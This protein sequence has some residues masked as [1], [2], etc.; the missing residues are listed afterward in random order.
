MELAEGGGHPM[1]PAICPSCHTSF[2]GL[3]ACPKCLFSKMTD[4]QILAS[5]KVIL[6]MANAK[7]AHAHAHLICSLCAGPIVPGEMRRVLSATSDAHLA[8]VRQLHEQLIELLPKPTA[9]GPGDFEFGDDAIKIEG[10]DN[11]FGAK[12]LHERP[13]IQQLKKRVGK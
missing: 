7:M 6:R 10:G 5:A 12:F 1:N 2:D 13:D 3:L 11:A 8:C 4:D 9:E